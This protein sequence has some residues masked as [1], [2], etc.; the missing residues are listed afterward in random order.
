MALKQKDLLTIRALPAEEITLNF[1]LDSRNDSGEFPDHD[2]SP[3]C[4][5]AARSRNNSAAISRWLWCCC[6]RARTTR[7][8][9]CSRAD[10]AELLV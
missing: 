9:T 2:P 1:N 5:P 4:V 10:H 6:Q 8:G 3:K 7:S